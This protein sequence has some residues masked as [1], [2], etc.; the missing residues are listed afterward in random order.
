MKILLPLNCS[1]PPMKIPVVFESMWLVWMSGTESML[2]T[3][4]SVVFMETYF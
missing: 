2:F 4:V 3:D 1:C